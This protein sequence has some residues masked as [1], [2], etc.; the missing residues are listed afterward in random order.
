ML[1]RVTGVRN[2]LGE[3]LVFLGEHE[4]DDLFARDLADRVHAE[5]HMPTW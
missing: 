3:S 5:M 4:S 2:N 1:A